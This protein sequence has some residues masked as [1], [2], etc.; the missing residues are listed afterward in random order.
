MSISPWFSRSLCF[1]A[2]VAA[3]GSLFAAG[4]FHNVTTDQTLFFSTGPAGGA[5]TAD[6]GKLV[7]GSTET[8]NVATIDSA[9]LITSV[10][11]PGLLAKAYAALANNYGSTGTPAGTAVSQPVSVSYETGLASALVVWKIT[12]IYTAGNTGAGTV[13][14]T[15]SK[16]A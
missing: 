8:A 9:N 15:L 12:A 1:A 2:L 6:G 3:S 14:Y 16:G 13:T 10:T 11:A 7:S 5:P 4:T